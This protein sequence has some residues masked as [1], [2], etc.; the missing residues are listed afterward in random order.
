MIKNEND[1]SFA[2]IFVVFASFL[3]LMT[4]SMARS[5][6]VEVKDPGFKGISLDLDGLLGS[7][8]DI[9]G[10]FLEENGLSSDIVGYIGPIE[11]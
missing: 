9:I 8:R 2:C 6:T 1:K 7:L 3:M 4:T 11:P 5:E 10:G